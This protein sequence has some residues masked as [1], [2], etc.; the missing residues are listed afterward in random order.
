MYYVVQKINKINLTRNIHD[1]SSLKSYRFD[2]GCHL[3]ITLQNLSTPLSLIWRIFLRLFV[4]IS[5]DR[6]WFEYFHTSFQR[7]NLVNV[8]LT[9]QTYFNSTNLSIF[10]NFLCFFSI[11]TLVSFSHNVFTEKKTLWKCYF[12][13]Y[14]AAICN[15]SNFFSTQGFHRKTCENVSLTSLH[16]LVSTY[17]LTETDWSAYLV[18]NI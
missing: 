1:F 12:Q 7:K 10:T 18:D 3:L 4:S 5:T 16:W 6:L 13:L 2:G 17:W 11:F 8:S 14:F 15:R 9:E